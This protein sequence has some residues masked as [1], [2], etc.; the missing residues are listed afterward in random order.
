VVTGPWHGDDWFIEAGLN[1]G[2]QVIVDGALTVRPGI[3]VKTVSY[4]AA[5]NAGKG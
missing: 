4:Q 1:G 3:E 2:E 5:S